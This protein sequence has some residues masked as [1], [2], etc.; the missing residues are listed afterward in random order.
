MTITSGT[1]L[2]VGEATF[3]GDASSEVERWLESQSYPNRFAQRDWRWWAEACLFA[4]SNRLQ[5]FDEDRSS[6]ARVRDLGNDITKLLT[7]AETGEV[8]LQHTE[9]GFYVRRWR[10]APGQV[11]SSSETEESSALQV[12]A[13]FALA[14]KN[15]REKLAEQNRLWEARSPEER[16]E[17][18][19]VR[20]IP[21]LRCALFV[22]H[23][24]VNLNAAMNAVAEVWGGASAWSG[25]APLPSDG[26]VQILVPLE[27]LEIDSQ[28][29]LLRGLQETELRV[30]CF[31]R[32]PYMA[33]TEGKLR[34]DLY[35]RLAVGEVDL[36]R[37]HP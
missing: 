4:D 30:V 17:E 16:F 11:L 3:T 18:V 20:S 31:S 7:R 13:A 2:L 35:Y 8:L 5:F 22:T 34:V 28:T 27:D 26:A 19:M 24:D 25:E 14:Q 10:V 29:K 9:N 12:P 33:T 32:D 15:F 37:V 36:S 1:H 21:G 23:D 6:Y